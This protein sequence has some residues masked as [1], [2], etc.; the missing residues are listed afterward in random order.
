MPVN[1]RFLAKR[2]FHC[3]CFLAA[4]LLTSLTASAQGSRLGDTFTPK[5]PDGATIR[6]PGVTYDAA[7][8]AYL[9]TWV[10]LVPSNAHRV[11]ARFVSADGV[12]LGLPDTVNVAPG[13]AS[14]AA[15]APELNACLIA[16]LQ[17]P[18]T[19]M[20]RMVRYSAGSIAYLTAPFVI[21][22]NGK[23]KL[24]SAA[25]GVAY[26]STSRE[27]LVAWSEFGNS[28]D[29]SGQRVNGDG[30]LAGTEIPVA[31]TGLYE[32]F[33]TVLYSA[34][35]NEYLVSYYQELVNGVNT[36]AARRVQ[37]LSGAIVG[38]NT[39]WA[40]AFDQY[41]DM[42]Y[43]SQTDQFLAVT[44][45]ILGRGWMLHGQLSDAA[46]QPI[47]GVLSLAAGGGG[48]GIGVTYNSV[49]NNY[50]AVY[51]SQANNEIWGVTIAPSGVPTTQFQV[52]VSGSKLSTQPRAAG[53]T[54]AARFLAVASN[55]YGS[56]MAQM[57][58]DGSGP[59]PPGVS[60]P[61]M[62]LDTPGSAA[63]VAGSGFTISGW[64]LDLGAV[65]GNGVDWVHVWAIPVNGAPGIF[66]GAAAVNIPRPDVAAQFGAQF[67]HSGFA[68]S[69]HLPPGTY[70]LFAF[71]RSTVAD[72]FNYYKTVRIG[73]SGERATRTADI[74]GDGRVDLTVYRPDNGF[75]YSLESQNGF[76]TATNTGW[77]GPQYTPIAGDFDGDGRA[78]RTV[79]D[80]GSGNWYTLKSGSGF[81]TAT[82][83]N[84]GGVGW[85]ATGGDFDGDGRS[86]YVVYNRK[87]GLWYGLLSTSGYTTSIS[88]SWGGN[89][90][91]LP[92]AAD[93]DGD[94][95]SD[96]AVYAP[97]TG[98][99]F[100]LTS[101]SNYTQSLHFTAGGSD[102]EPVQ[103][104]FDGDGRTDPAVYQ[105]STGLWYGLKSSSNYTASVTINWGGAGYQ[106]VRG[107][108]DGDGRADLA[109]Y[110]TST[111]NWF[112]LLSGSGYTSAIVKN[113]GGAGYIPIPI[114]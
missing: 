25:P 12:S 53:S 31:T 96:V 43:N 37:P 49:S 78:D 93:Y 28:L 73:V 70:D 19:I 40:S 71:G 109:V 67:G 35:S 22:S 103:G 2:P 63:S 64:A 23:G 76:A 57:V 15:C 24:S 48:D 95:R 79:Y 83:I 50:F 99:W 13:G 105:A 66:V 38:G 82:S 89:D 11:G 3:G 60:A 1:F 32:A 42:A 16:W 98:D 41:P 47:G 20:G 90:A 94:G 84:V 80:H 113:W 34:R 6:F 9:V 77:G 4:A 111:G 29:V 54:K 106:P 46:A 69:G 85:T 100:V 30:S 104:D 65:D 75:W 114:S 5:P 101:S 8:D 52:T 68:L 18:T 97:A 62:S 59:P 86:D 74:D 27:F 58:Q 108:Y 33:P 72:G 10:G 92:V 110:Q 88:I 107:D 39:L 112:I 61:R 44:W 81:T 21:N 87:S 55:T 17:E 102:Y 91:Y 7:N 56:V 14:R 36:V 26:S 51:Q 45:G